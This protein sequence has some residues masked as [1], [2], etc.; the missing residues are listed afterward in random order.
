MATLIQFKT[1]PIFSALSGA[2][3][4]DNDLQVMVESKWEQIVENRNFD[5]KAL[6]NN[7]NKLSILEPSSHYL[8]PSAFR[9][10]ICFYDI[11]KIDHIFSK[12]LKTTYSSTKDFAVERNKQDISLFNE[13]VVSGSELK[14]AQ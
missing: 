5:L 8:S 9:K 3:L 10:A 1:R 4:P 2:S 7:D 12:K 11:D 6:G 14:S 13:V